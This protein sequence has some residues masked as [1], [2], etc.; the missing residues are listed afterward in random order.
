MK[1][2]LLAVVMVAAFLAVAAAPGSFAGTVVN[3]P[4]RSD[5]WLYVQ[6]RNHSVRRVYVSG[7]KFHYGSEVP[8][9]ERKKPVPTILPAGTLLR[10][11][12]EQDGAGEWRASDV[13]IL[14][15]AA[16]VDEKKTAGST[17]SQSSS[18]SKK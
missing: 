11:T 18:T 1:V 3:G 10:V 13:E 7:A 16:T 12:A 2:L 9:S 8:V 5:A 14:E 6:G 4:E 15:N 17:T